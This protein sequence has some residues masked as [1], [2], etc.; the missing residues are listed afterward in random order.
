MSWIQIEDTL[1]DHR[2]VGK[3]AALLKIDRDA[4]VGKLLRLWLWIVNNREDG[5]F[6]ELDF[7]TIAIVMRYREDPDKLIDALISAGFVDEEDDGYIVHDWI[8]R[9]QLLL[10][11]RER[12]RKQTAERVRKYRE[13]KKDDG[14]ANVTRYFTPEKRS[15]NAPTIQYSTEPTVYPSLS[16]P[17]SSSL[18]ASGRT[19][20]RK[21]IRSVEDQIEAHILKEVYDEDLVDAIA[22]EIKNSINGH[23]PEM[24]EICRQIKFCHVE[25]VIRALKDTEDVRNPA[26]FLRACL[27]NALLN[28]AANQI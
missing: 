28:E 27:K 20:G 18:K 12:V 17:P 10:E 5:T 14:N 9:M 23:D 26:A 2:K 7:E 6:S 3:L 19:E 4:V 15:C 1:P 11:K 16:F 25:Q 21:D 13:R 24:A 8:D 22:L